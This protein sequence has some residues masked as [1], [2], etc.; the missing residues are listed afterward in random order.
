MIIYEKAALVFH[1]L[2]NMMIDLQTMN[3]D[4]F[5]NMLKEFYKKFRGGVCTTKDFRK[6]TEKHLGLDMTW[7][8]DQWIYGTDLPTYK[9]SYEIEE[10]SAGQFVTTGRILTEG[11]SEGFK[12]YVPLEV[13]FENGKKVYIRMLID[14]AAFDFSLPPL[15]LKPKKIKLNPFESVLARVEQ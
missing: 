6:V 2:R 5:F 14:K 8:F 15:E 7:F 4:R 9:F 11:V 1:M 3:E 10:D 13:E 12:M